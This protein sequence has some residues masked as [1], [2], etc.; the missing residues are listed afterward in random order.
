M[1]RGSTLLLGALLVAQAAPAGAFV[2]S[3]SQGCN[4]LYWPISCIYIKPDSGLSADMA[5]AEVKQIIQ[6]SIDSWQDRTV[7][8][9]LKMKYQEPDGPLEARFDLQPTIKFR[10][11]KWCRPGDCSGDRETCHDPAATGITTVFYINKPDDPKQDGRILDADIELNAV[12][13]RFFNADNPPPSQ[14]DTRNL[15][16]LQN[17]LVHELGHLQGLDHTC[18]DTST[19]ACVVDQNGQ[20]PPLCSTVVAGAATNPTYK[21]IAD[22]TMFASATAKE[23]KK[24]VPKA[25]DLAAISSIYPAASDPKSCTVP[26]VEDQCTAGNTGC[27]AA[28][29]SRAAEVAPLLLVGAALGGA[30]LRRRRRA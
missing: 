18:R 16:D 25:D 2:R 11:G 12:N 13:N 20:Q 23:T 1:R 6:Q 15:A 24:R 14:T 28:P 7:G 30:L 5:P 21:E 10:T 9:F 27:S 4:P 22:T 17:T 3:R 26:K 19:R 8:S 29:R